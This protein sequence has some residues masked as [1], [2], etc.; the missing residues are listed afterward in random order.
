METEHEL[1]NINSGGHF[2]QYLGA[3]IFFEMKSILYIISF[4]WLPF[5]LVLQV[6]ERYFQQKKFFR[7]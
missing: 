1:E 5:S 6:F 7:F 2:A 3:M 4:Q